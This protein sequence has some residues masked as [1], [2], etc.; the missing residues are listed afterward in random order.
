MQLTWWIVG[1][2]VLG[3]S[4]AWTTNTAAKRHLSSLAAL[5]SPPAESSASSSS[6]SSSSTPSSS[7]KKTRTR[8]RP[9]KL[10]EG[11]KIIDFSSV[12]A[13]SRAEQALAQARR[14]L[15]TDR[16]AS[17]KGILGIKQED[18]KEIG[19]ELGAFATAKQ[20]Q[21][22]AAYI[23]SKAQPGLLSTSD[24]S[25][26]TYSD[27]QIRNFKNIL[28]K[29]YFESGEITGAYAKTF[30]MGTM[31]ME[32]AAREAI[33]AVYVWCRRT[34]E[35][36]DAG[37]TEK[38]ML[39]DLAAW[40]IRLEDLWIH[41]KVVDVFDLCLLD[42]RVKY[43]TLDITPFMDMIRGMLMDVPRLGQDRYD[44]F[45]DL[46]L[47]CY[48]V[49]GTVGV[50]S[51]PI[52]G[53]APGFNDHVARYVGRRSFFRSVL[54]CHS[55]RIVHISQGAGIIVGRGV[56]A[57]EYSARCG[58]RRIQTRPRVFAAGRLEAIWRDGGPDFRKAC[59]SELHS[60]DE[61]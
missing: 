55:L 36:V 13:S 42:V 43:P 17:T 47:Y 24:A 2:V 16:F 9:G 4:S 22:C 49:A 19:Y 12:K 48:R 11:G 23:R 8:I 52:F 21:D 45:D 26:Q 10:L 50:M 51:L 37:E 39:L 33:W 18:I 5:A 59:R 61:V 57:D 6:S 35:I 38:D 40:E 53:C 30:Y 46:H 29:A 41:G 3:Q 25:L 7:A 1:L 44:N 14:E 20:I 32:P 15:T 56:P 34:D 58:G 31:L 60:V 28:E 27:E 54:E